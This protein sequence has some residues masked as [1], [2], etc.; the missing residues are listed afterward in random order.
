MQHAVDDGLDEIR[1]V[2]GADHDVSELARPG[3][4]LIRVDRERQDVGGAVL[5]AMLAVQLADALGADQLDR[6]VPILDPGGAQRGLRRDA[7]ARLVC[8][9][10][11]Q[12][13]ARRRSS[14]ACCEACSS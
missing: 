12:R 6:Q 7:E 11:D 8:L 3:D 14:C 1:R 9:D 4:R 2:L 13:E 5:S 10:L